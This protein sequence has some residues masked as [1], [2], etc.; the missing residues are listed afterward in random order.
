MKYCIIHENKKRRKE[1]KKVRVDFVA[2][3]SLVVAVEDG[4]DYLNRAVDV[5]LE[6]VY[7]ADYTPVWEVED[8]GVDDAKET[9][10]V[11]VTEETNE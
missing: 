8:D 6:H 5:A 3:M 7:D 9:D 4:V 1:M 11:D 10:D 2:H